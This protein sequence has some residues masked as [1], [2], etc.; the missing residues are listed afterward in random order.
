MTNNTIIL[1][2]QAVEPVVI[3]DGHKQIQEFKK[4]VRLHGICGN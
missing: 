1:N 4:V 3:G 2:G